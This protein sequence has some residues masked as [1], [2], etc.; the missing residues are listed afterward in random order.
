MKFYSLVPIAA[1]INSNFG[2]INSL[3]GAT[4]VLDMMSEGCPS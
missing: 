1:A 3:M 4:R 2:K